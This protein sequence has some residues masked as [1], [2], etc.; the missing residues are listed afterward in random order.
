MNGEERKGAEFLGWLLSPSMCA[1]SCGITNRFWNEKHLYCF[2]IQS[3]EREIQ[4]NKRLSFFKTQF[5]YHWKNA[6]LWIAVHVVIGYSDTQRYT[7]KY[8]IFPRLVFE[9][10]K[11][12][13]VGYILLTAT[14][15]TGSVK[16]ARSMLMLAICPQCFAPFYS[17]LYASSTMQL[18]LR[19][20]NYSNSFFYIVCV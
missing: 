4:T 18:M 3:W 5:Q 2:S 19:I 9:S 10:N 20:K 7:M 17:G 12:G 16:L 8:L 1:Q 13:S 15:A 6:A 14:L 11:S